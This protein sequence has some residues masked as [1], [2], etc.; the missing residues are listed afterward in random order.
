MS[1][2]NIFGNGKIRT[3]IYF[4]IYGTDAVLQRFFGRT[5]VDFFAV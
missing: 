5:V 1:D 3:K 4:L 2:E